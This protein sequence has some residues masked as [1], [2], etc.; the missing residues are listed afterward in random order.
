M[1]WILIGNLMGP[2]G[3]MGPR[4]ADGLPGVNAVA[5]D[6]A[7][8]GYIST[9]GTSATKTALM[10]REWDLDIR[11]FG[12]VGDGRLIAS[13]AMT[14][15]SATLTASTSVF[16]AGDVG[17][18]VT[19]FGAGTAGAN[20]STTIAGYTSGT[21]VTLATPAVTT[22]ATANAYFGT[23]NTTAIRAAVTASFPARS[24]RFPS[25]GSGNFYQHGDT[26]TVDATR[27]SIRF[28][29]S[30]RDAY[31]VSIR[32]FVAGKTQFLIKAPGVVF[33]NLGLVG[34][35][36]NTNGGN[37]IGATTTGI[38]YWGDAD[39]NGDSATRG[40]TIQ[41][42]AIAIRTRS[43][44]NVVSDECLFSNCLNGVLING[45][46]V[47][48]HTGPGADQNRGNTIK[49]SKF[50]NIGTLTSH[51][52]VQITS[53]A[54]LIHAQIE[55]NHFDSNGL[56]RHIVATGTSTDPFKNLTIKDNKHSELGADGIVLT[57]GQ[58]WTLDGSDFFGYT[59]GYFSGHAV[60]I[61][62]CTG[63]RVLNVSGLQIGKSG[64]KMT[65]SS[66][67][68]IRSTD[69]TVVGMDTGAV[70]SGVDI[71]STNSNISLKGYSV[72]TSPGFGFT[73]EV[74]NSS[75][76]G[77][78]FTSCTLG[79]INSLTL[80]NR[81]RRGANDYVE[82]KFGRLEDIASKAITTVAATALPIATIGGGGTFGTYLLDIEFT[83]N[84][85]G[86]L[87]ST[88]RGTRMISP[89]NGVPVST[90]VGTDVATNMGG[91]PITVVTASTSSVT[92]SITTTN[93][94]W[95]TVRLKASAGGATN[96][97][98]VRGVSV[99]LI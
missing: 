30:P 22:V 48:Y 42:H 9:L 43:R 95:G 67:I 53:D 78:E 17:K 90:V 89:V 36:S 98:N 28:I 63:G 64:L 44:N 79:N 96:G 60:V 26:I 41:G 45:K 94:V 83:G 27:P 19:V 51:A 39:G 75:S 66:A 70:Y 62:N 33:E 55:G 91:T 80:T 69:F 37:G 72:S 50:H 92:V 32:C 29:G 47:T 6:T 15:G 21:V 3:P 93:A 31:S 34:D 5:N 18:I 54:K 73:G 86:N 2:M 68:K 25:T 13:S 76:E 58:Y 88:F 85:V 11:D 24:I 35:S 61:D 16:A 38:E 82:G 74:V 8:A 7:T 84:S 87:I 4:G 52:A 65:N 20:L 59:A 81:A 14:N 97:T 57:Y 46:D 99:A 40:V 1:A 12:G 10:N 56:G 71:D 23:D 77:G 49:S